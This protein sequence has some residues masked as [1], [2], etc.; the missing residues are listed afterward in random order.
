MIQTITLH[1]AKKPG[2]PKDEIDLFL[3][4]LDRWEKSVFRNF[5]INPET[6]RPVMVDVREEA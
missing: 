3:E 5:R 4:S 6:G 2:D 1:R